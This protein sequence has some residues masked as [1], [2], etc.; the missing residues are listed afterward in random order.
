MAV[1]VT[2]K[3]NSSNEAGFVL[4]CQLNGDPFSVIAQ[5]LPAGTTSYEDATATGSTEGDNVYTYRVKAFN[6]AG[7]SEYSNVSS[8]TIPQIVTTPNAPSDLT[9]TAL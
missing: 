5:S 3:D 2:W 9:A 7:A 8:V 1:K 4:E 6:T